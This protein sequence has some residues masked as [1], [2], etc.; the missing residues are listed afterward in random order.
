MPLLI[1]YRLSEAKKSCSL[2]S[3]SKKWTWKV[4]KCTLY[5]ANILKFSAFSYPHC[6]PCR[7]LFY[8][9]L[10]YFLLIWKILTLT[11]QT[12]LFLAPCSLFFWQSIPTPLSFAFIFSLFF[13][14]SLEN[15][16][17]LASDPNSLIPSSLYLL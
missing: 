11:F 10:C 2:S 9:Q 7:Y 6:P 8:V 3:F 5:F 17:I 13:F 1:Q 16:S 12:L 4:S 14:V 15:S